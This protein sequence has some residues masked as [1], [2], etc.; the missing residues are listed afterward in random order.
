MIP[1]S[2]TEIEDLAFEG[3]TNFPSIIL[4]NSLKKIGW[5]AFVGCTGLTEI[6]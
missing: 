2:V 6:K 4:P 5:G 1:D 3:C